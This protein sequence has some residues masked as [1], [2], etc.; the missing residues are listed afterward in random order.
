VVAEQ[1]VDQ[2]FV[3]VPGQRRPV[4]LHRLRARE[5]PAD[6]VYVRDQILATIAAA[7]ASGG[8]RQRLADAKSFN[9]YAFARTLDSTERIAGGRR[10]ASYKRSYDTVNAYYRTLD[11]LTPADLQAA[12]RKYF[13]DAG[14]IVTTL[15]KEPL[16]AGIERAG[17]A[18]SS[19]R[20]RSRRPR[21]SA[22]PPPRSR[23]PPR[24]PPATRPVR[25]VRRSRCCRS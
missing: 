2:L 24:L 6:A 13:T 5:E 18:R 1:K 23:T 9:R 21:G 14:L 22:R 10:Y 8:R 3:D 4:A 17:L 16:P 19:R 12:A 15:S 25:L 7:R 20:P 11:S